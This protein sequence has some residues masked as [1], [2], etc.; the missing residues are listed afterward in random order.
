[1]TPLT[2]ISDIDRSAG[3]ENGENPGVVKVVC[4]VVHDLE[5][6]IESMSQVFA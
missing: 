5:A 4:G 6:E 3:G 2:I 1:M